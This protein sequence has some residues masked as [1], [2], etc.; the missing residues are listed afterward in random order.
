MKGDR[1]AT[2]THYPRYAS[3]A[4]TLTS[5]HRYAGSFDVYTIRIS[6]DGGS[7]GDGQLEYEIRP[8]CEGRRARVVSTM[9]K[10]LR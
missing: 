4:S 8:L 6:N 5:D 1:L 9:E 10:E 7:E 2:G 3:R